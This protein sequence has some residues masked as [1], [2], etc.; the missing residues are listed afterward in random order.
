MNK[1][2]S[3]TYK[4]Q[5]SVGKMQTLK[6]HIVVVENIIPLCNNNEMDIMSI[7]KSGMMYE[8]EVKISRADFKAD[9]K[10]KKW[11]WHKQPHVQMCPNYFSYCCPDGLIAINE[12]PPYC[13][14]YY[15]I[16]NELKE[17]RKPKRLH[18]EIG[19]I[20]KIKDKVLRLTS[21]RIFL[22]CARLTYENNLIKE[23]HKQWIKQQQHR[24]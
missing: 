9:I 13:G 4:I 15:F 24:V 5:K 7:S 22:G 21:E 16:D 8:F 1:S 18:K 2:E 19:D 11:Y 12:I 17:I 3:K 10:K 20:P 23:R 14:L 6:H